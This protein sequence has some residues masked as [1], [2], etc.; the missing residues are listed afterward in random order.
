[1]KPHVLCRWLALAAALGLTACAPGSLPPSHAIVSKAG[2]KTTVIPPKPVAETPAVP[3]VPVAPPNSGPA[4]LRYAGLADVVGAWGLVPLPAGVNPSNYASGQFSEPYQYYQILSDG[5]FGTVRTFN[6]PVAPVTDLDVQ[7]TLTM[8]PGY[9]TYTLGNGIMV[10]RPYTVTGVTFQGQQ[11]WAVQSVAT[12]GTI[13]GTYAL[14]GD[15][16]MTL[17]NQVNGQPYYRILRRLPPAI[18]GAN[19]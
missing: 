17:Q 13:L 7:N 3:A 15:L 18:Y 14:P 11:V 2:P 5:R 12:A 8:Q 4:M 19:P 10:V 16:F 6:A 1:M 9:D